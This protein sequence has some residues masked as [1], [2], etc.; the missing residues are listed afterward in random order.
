MEL[1]KGGLRAAPATWTYDSVKSDFAVGPPPMPFRV[2]RQGQGIVGLPW[3]SVAPWQELSR[4]KAFRRT[5]DEEPV[6]V[7]WRQTLG[8]LRDEPCDPERTGL[9]LR[10]NPSGD[11]I[12]G[13]PD[14]RV[15]DHAD[16]SRDCQQHHS[17]QEL[18]TQV[19][20]PPD[21]CWW[22]CASGIATRSRGALLSR[23]SWHQGGRGD[24]VVCRPSPRCLGL[25]NATPAAHAFRGGEGSDTEILMPLR[26][27]R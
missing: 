26:S 27:A 11:P 22:T 7:S 19:P 8:G 12:S 20:G 25:P 17:C 15:K 24:V 14:D 5:A 4:D 21:A 6:L 16:G 13:P 3:R 23:H 9:V 2:P 10:K 1:R 18:G